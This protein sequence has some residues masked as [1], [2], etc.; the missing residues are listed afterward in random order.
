VLALVA[1]RADDHLERRRIGGTFLAGPPEERGCPLPVPRELQRREQ[2]RDVRAEELVAAGGQEGR[3]RGSGCEEMASTSACAAGERKECGGV[4]VW[5]DRRGAGAS[6][7]RWSRSEWSGSDEVEAERG[8]GCQRAENCEREGQREARVDG[9]G[10]D[11]RRRGRLTDD[12]QKHGRGMDGGD[13]GTAERQTTLTFL[14]SS[15]DVVNF[16]ENVIQKRFDTNFNDE[17][18]HSNTLHMNFEPHNF[19]RV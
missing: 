14:I 7:V 4:G 15:I 16:K 3:E 9:E 17:G 8:S 5:C 18:N 1:Q 13:R 10:A 2:G 12:A 11:G 6:A 19:F